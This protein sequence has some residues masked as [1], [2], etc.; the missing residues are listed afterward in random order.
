MEGLKMRKL[1]A[2]HRF[3]GYFFFALLFNVFGNEVA[4]AA[5]EV[6][7]TK[8]CQPNTFC[9]PR[10]QGARV[11]LITG[12]PGG[13]TLT[14]NTTTNTLGIATFSSS[15]VSDFKIIVSKSGYVGQER[16][17]SSPASGQQEFVLSLGSGGPQCVALIQSGSGTTGTGSDDGVSFTMERPDFIVSS[18]SV[19]PSCWGTQSKVSVTVKNQGNDETTF[20]SSSGTPSQSFKVK[21]VLRASSWSKTLTKTVSLPH[22]LEP[23][24]TTVV[25]FQNVSIPNEAGQDIYFLATADSSKS[26]TESDETNNSNS[27]PYK[28]TI[29]QYCSGEA[30]PPTHVPTASPTPIPTKPSIVTPTPKPTR[31]RP[32]KPKSKPTRLRQPEPTPKK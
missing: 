25:N 24:D 23:G 15:P 28:T 13:L 16:E 27:Q 9:S 31:L 8:Q 26:I 12:P 14:Q 30:P 6:Y 29:T 2:T 18:L 5:V 4:Q 3:L 22:R 32:S 21:L 7:V 10:L 17:Y 19:D 1:S 20:G 11:C